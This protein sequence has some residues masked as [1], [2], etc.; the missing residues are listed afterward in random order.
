MRNEDTG[1]PPHLRIAGELDHVE[2]SRHPLPIKEARDRVLRAREQVTRQ[3]S[4]PFRAMAD[5][6]DD[7]VVSVDVYPGNDGQPWATGAKVHSPSSWCPPRYV[8][9]IVD[10][11]LPYQRV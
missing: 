8:S 10:L 9:T 3:A 11:Q 4:E 1:K 6:D 5:F 7:L 2:T